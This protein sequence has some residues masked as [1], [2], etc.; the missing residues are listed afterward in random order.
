META[1][2]NIS[3]ETLM[4]KE[5]T[6]LV[7]FFKTLNKVLLILNIIMSF[8]LAYYSSVTY[9]ERQEV[10]SYLKENHSFSE[11]EDTYDTLSYTT[12]NKK[13]NDLVLLIVLVLTLFA[14]LFYYAFNLLFIKHFSNLAELKHI[15]KSEYLNTQMKN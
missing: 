12:T 11:D 13:Y 10:Q 3:T 14:S 6:S 8:P 15:T 2:K 9:Q 4:D 5:S 1:N 7:T